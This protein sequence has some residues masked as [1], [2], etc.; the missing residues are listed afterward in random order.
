MDNAVYCALFDIKYAHFGLTLYST[1][2][3]Y[4]DAKIYLFPFDNKT[5]DL[6]T[7]LSL[8][9]TVIVKQSEF[10]NER[11]LKVKPSR[12]KSEYCWTCT[13]SII[14]Y[15]LKKYNESLCIY[16]DSDLGFFND[17]ALL[18]SE[19]EGKSVLI[20]GH[21]FSSENKHHEGPSGTYNVQFVGFRNDTNG[22]TV[23]N[24]WCDRCIEW[25]YARV[26]GGKFGDQKYLDGWPQKFKGVH[27]L[28]HIGGGMA[29]WNAT[30]F[31]I[32]KENGVLMANETKTG[33]KQPLV[34][35]HFHDFC[36]QRLSVNYRLP[37]SANLIYADYLDDLRK[38]KETI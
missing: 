38:T 8:I 30:Q 36:P 29:P 13:S 15:I 3:K 34:F 9:N 27:V 35:Y 33:I 12:T 19:F 28:K 18:L 32:T 7:S 5:Y 16:L 2:R 1:F 23:L 31:T 22:N 4:S 26:E 25:C 11:L 37:K 10:E 24:W 20:T 17:P 6:L 21:N 14:R